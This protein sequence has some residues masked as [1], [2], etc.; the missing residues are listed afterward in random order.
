MGKEL[1]MAQIHRGKVLFAIL[2]VSPYIQKTHVGKLNDIR[3]KDKTRF[4]VTKL[5]LTI[6]NPKITQV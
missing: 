3:N 2:V 1:E 5:W 4:E 6:K